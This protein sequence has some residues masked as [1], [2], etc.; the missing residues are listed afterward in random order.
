MK[1]LITLIVCIFIGIVGYYSYVKW[2]EEV[3]EQANFATWKTFQPRSKLFE[4][5]LPNQPQYAKEFLPIS[6]SDKRRR[7]DL[8]ASEKVDGTLFLIS[9][10]S[11]PQDYTFDSSEVLAEHIEEFLKSKLKNKMSKSEKTHHQNFEAMDFGYK[12]EDFLIEGKSI[13]GGN[14]IYILSYITTI[15]NFDKDEYNHFIDSFK[16]LNRKV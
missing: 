14:I 6:N 9:V 8:Y 7:Y 2:S 13:K 5:N 1:Y 11:Y 10:I 16:I 15:K 3:G 4:V 12:S